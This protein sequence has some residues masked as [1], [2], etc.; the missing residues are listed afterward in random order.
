M[1]D[2]EIVVKCL[3]TLI[4]QHLPFIDCQPISLN[5]FR[6]ILC[7]ESFKR[8]IKVKT[9]KRSDHPGTIRMYKA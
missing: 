8:K 5:N 6:V 9:K 3:D 2:R 7:N 1:K 4:N